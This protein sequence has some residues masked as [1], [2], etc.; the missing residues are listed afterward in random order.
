MSI[1][2]RYCILCNY[3]RWL[4]FK[5]VKNNFKSQ[6][7]NYKSIPHLIYQILN[8]FNPIIIIVIIIRHKALKT[9]PVLIKIKFWIVLKI[10]LNFSYLPNSVHLSIIHVGAVA[11]QKIKNKKN[12]EEK[13]GNEDEHWD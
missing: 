5:V 3:Y 6:P 7:L 10:D 9:W 13:H 8:P 11:G 12:I 4:R 1:E 2:I